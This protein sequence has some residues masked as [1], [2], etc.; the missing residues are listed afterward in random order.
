[1]RRFV[2]SFALAAIAAAAMIVPALADGIG[3]IG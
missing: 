1:M 2:V 3:P